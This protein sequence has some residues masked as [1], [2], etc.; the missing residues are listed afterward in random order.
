MI[1]AYAV[2][3]YRPIASL[4]FVVLVISRLM[5]ALVSTILFL[6]ITVHSQE[7]DFRWSQYHYQYV[8]AGTIT[9]KLRR[10]SVIV[11]DQLPVSNLKGQSITGYYVQILV[12]TPAQKFNVVVDTGSSNLAVSL[13]ITHDLCYNVG[14]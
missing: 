11:K 2:S 10:R 1:P 5:I 3:V 6:L 14:F 7:I 13:D 12:G 4:F 9:Y 8:G